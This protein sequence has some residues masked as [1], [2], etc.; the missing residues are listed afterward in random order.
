MFIAIQAL[1]ICPVEGVLNPSSWS[2]DIKSI[3][4]IITCFSDELILYAQYASEIRHLLHQIKLNGVSCLWKFSNYRP[5]FHGAQELHDT[6]E[7]SPPPLGLLLWAAQGFAKIK[8]SKQDEMRT[9]QF[10]EIRNTIMHIGDYT[11]DFIATVHKG[12]WEYF[13]DNLFPLLTYLSSK[14]LHVC[15]TDLV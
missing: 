6:R 2:P 5:A 15:F 9:K 7:P 3:L 1:S 12:K 4:D 11:K 14:E 13:T 10:S 8:F